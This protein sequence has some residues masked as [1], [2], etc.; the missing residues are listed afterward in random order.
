MGKVRSL[1]SVCLIVL[2]NGSSAG[3]W[4]VER[5]HVTVY[6]HQVEAVYTSQHTF[7][8]ALSAE[9]EHKLWKVTTTIYG[10]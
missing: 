7:S 2:R 8:S 3:H 4:Q 1:P 10:R 9:L 5:S 6:L